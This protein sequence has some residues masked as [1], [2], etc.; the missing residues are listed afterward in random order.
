M[1]LAAVL[2]LFLSVQVSSGKQPFT[3]SLANHLSGTVI[4]EKFEIRHGQAVNASIIRVPGYYGYHSILG[5][6][7]TYI[8]YQT[9]L[10]SLKTWRMANR[11]F[12]VIHLNGDNITLS[13]VYDA[14]QSLL[15]LSLPPG[16]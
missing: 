1:K 15:L 7:D 8:L 9:N 5:V 11:N 14:Q 6:I 3:Q 4:E 2:L 16:Y 10:T 12:Y 13:I